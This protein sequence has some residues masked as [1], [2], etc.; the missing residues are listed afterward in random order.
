MEVESTALEGVLLFRPRPF[1]DG[2]GFFSRTWD[3]AVG[4]EWG[5]RRG[6]HVQ[7]SQSRSAH[8]VLRGLH[9]R[10]A[11]G[12]AKIIRVAHGA[13]Q[14]VVVD[15]RLESPTLGRHVTV[16]LDDVDL[17][18]IRVPRRMLT[19]FYV[20]GEVADVCYAMD[21]VHDGDHAVAVHHA[22]P[23]LA[24]DWPGE[25]GTL[26]ERDRVAGTWQDYLRSTAGA[27]DTEPV[28]ASDSVLNGR[29]R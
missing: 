14:F 28:G 21:R 29:A 13:A 22:D 10:G 17:V 7:D 27:P 18:S 5:V 3:S 2:R 20:V 1:R 11:G 23:D 25:P 4:E 8:G 19:G 16:R 15:G 26:S 24:I 6:D 12:E 9:G